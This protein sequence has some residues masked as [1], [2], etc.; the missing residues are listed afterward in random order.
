[1]HTSLRA[2]LLVLALPA[3]A[4]AE[5]FEVIHPD[6]TEGWFEF[7]ILNTIILDNVGV[8]EERSVHE[9][10]LGYAPTSFWKTTVALEAATIRGDGSTL[11]AFEWENV[12]LFFGGDGHDDHDH[13]GHDHDHGSGF[14]LEALG[15]YGALEVP[16]EGGIQTGGAA[17]GPVAELALGPVHT[18]ANLLVEIPFDE[19]EDP[20]LA[21][22]LSAAVPV[23]E[24]GS[25][26][27]AAGFEA[28]GGV[29]GLFGSNTPPLGQNAHLLG[30]AA[31]EVINL[32][33]LAVRAKLSA[34]DLK[35]APLVFPS[36]GHD[37]RSMV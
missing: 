25:A 7:E 10:A 14:G 21:Y 18:V 19:G 33:A 20:G 31:H 30:P 8:G 2:A 9:F 17:I 32:C 3:A 5:V 36:A 23:F 28:F 4:Q 29:E 1:M 16:R 34:A 12:L 24:T 15:L 35:S 26:E 27:F 22:A 6:V 37:L 11:E 13:D